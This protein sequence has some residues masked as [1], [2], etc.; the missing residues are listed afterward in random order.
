MRKEQLLR[1]IFEKLDISQTMHDNA[2][3]KYNNLAKL[4]EEKEIKASIYPQGSFRIGT[5]VRPYKDGRDRDYDLDFV[6]QIDGT[7]EDF[8]PKVLKDSVGDILK[9]D[10]RYTS[11]LTEYN[12]CWTIKYADISDGI[13]FNIDIVPATSETQV[14]IE[15]LIQNG[16]VQ[17]K[18]DKAIAI[19]H[20]E[21]N[22]FNWISTNSSAYAEWFEEKNKMAFSNL[23]YKRKSSIYEEYKSIYNSV[24][25]VPDYK[26]KTPLQRSIQILKRH[27][28]IYY[29]RSNINSY[30]PASVIITTLLAE[31]ASYANNTNEIL[32]FLS[33]SIEELRNMH[34]Y[35]S[36]NTLLNPSEILGKMISRTGKDEWELKNPVNPED[37]FLDC[38]NSKTA[39][40]F[41]QW[42]EEVEKDLLD[43][44]M[45]EKYTENN[46]ESSLGIKLS[47]S[48][49]NVNARKIEPVQPWKE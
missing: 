7:K 3:E 35:F 44:D 18:A 11:K 10:G 46:I 30:K 17:E 42:L 47:Q 29:D 24:E 31:I 16:I 12:R 27:R 43:S 23:I 38:W 21:D 25:E 2:T 5:V 19:T 36:S 48:Q 8:E 34:P 26:V 41:F 32:S 37:N 9:E 49:P 45:I 14:F 6:C 22:V 20:K 4:F 15:S 39:V 40:F 33:S 1:E 28:D 13:G